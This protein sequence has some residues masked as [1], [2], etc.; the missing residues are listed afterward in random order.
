MGL[1]L[2]GWSMRNY[3]QEVQLHGA[4]SAGTTRVSSAGWLNTP[5]VSIDQVTE[6]TRI[7]MPVNT[8]NPSSE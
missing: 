1:F 3:T 7:M 8:R 2:A 6:Q 5:S 4:E